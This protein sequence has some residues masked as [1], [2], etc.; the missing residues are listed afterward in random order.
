MWGVPWLGAG[1]GR[2]GD[3][4]AQIAMRQLLTGQGSFVLPRPSMELAAAGHRFDLE[5]NQH[6]EAIRE[7]VA[8]F[9]EAV[10]VWARRLRSD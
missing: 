4:P 2:F 7:R 1:G 8:G 9:I 3:A 6:D 10:A 5:G